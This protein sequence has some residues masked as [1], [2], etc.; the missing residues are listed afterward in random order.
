MQPASWSSS[1]GRSILIT[2]TDTSTGSKSSED[3]TRAIPKINDNPNFTINAKKT[4]SGETFPT[5][6]RLNRRNPVKMVSA[7]SSLL[8]S[9]LTYSRKLSTEKK[10]LRRFADRF[11]MLSFVTPLPSPSLGC[12]LLR[13]TNDVSISGKIYRASDVVRARC[14]KPLPTDRYKTS[15]KP[16]HSFYIRTRF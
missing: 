11:A 16:L 6:L 7:L 1:C 9:S 15:E 5:R 2:C 13:V 4:T 14:N 8:N 12:Y 10:S 3:E